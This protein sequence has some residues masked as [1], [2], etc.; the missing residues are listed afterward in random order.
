[1]NF[2]KEITTLLDCVEKRV[3]R[4]IKSPI[5]FDMLSLRISEQITEQIS[6]TT[7]K[8]IWG[9]ITTEH[10]PRYS[11]LSTLARFVGYVDWDDFCHSNCTAHEADS[12]F[13]SCKQISVDHLAVGSRIELSWRPNRRCIVV[14]NGQNMFTVEEA[15]GAKII[16]GDTFKATTFLLGHPLYMS[17]L[18]RGNDVPRSYIAGNRY[19]LSGLTVLK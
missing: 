7:L 11:T 14:Y 1:M 5:D 15:F 19:G 13:I 8:R 6:T 16:A 17:E 3:G 10:T 2:N 18:C 12:G 4:P 9:Y